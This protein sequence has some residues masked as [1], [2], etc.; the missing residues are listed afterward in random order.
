MTAR[1]DQVRS[2]AEARAAPMANDGLVK[3]RRR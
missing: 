3:A 1:T 2:I